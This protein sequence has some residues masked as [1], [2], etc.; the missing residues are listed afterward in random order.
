MGGRLDTLTRDT[1]RSYLH[2]QLAVLLQGGTLTLATVAIG[3][4]AGQEAL[5]RFGWVLSAV[6][7]VSLVGGLGFKEGVAVL[8]QREREDPEAL[9]GLFFRCL[10][11]RVAAALVAAIAVAAMVVANQGQTAFAAAVSAYVLFVLLGNLFAAFDIA[12]FRTRAVALGR[13]ASAVVGL[14]LTVAGALIGSLALVFAGLAAGAAAA[15]VIFLLPLAQLLKGARKSYALRGL[16]GLSLTLWL[17]AILNYLVGLNAAPLV[18]KTAHMGEG[19][20]G[21]FTAAF[22]LVFATN[23]ALTGGFANVI[24]AAFSRAGAS[25]GGESLAR[26][27]SLYVRVVAIL[28]V[29]LLLGLVVFARLAVRIPLKGDTA[30]AAELLVIL[31][32]A[33]VVIRLLGGGAHSAALYATGHHVGDLVIRFAFAAVSVAVTY[34]AAVSGNLKAAVVAAGAAGAGVIAAEWVYLHVKERIGMPVREL[35][36]IF[37]GCAAAALPAAAMVR[38]GTVFATILAI[39]IFVVGVVLAFG[40]VKPLQRGEVERIG[41]KGIVADILTRFESE[42]EDVG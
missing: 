13:L 38:I 25:E 31:A 16:F 39:V 3:K 15:A 42:D 18:L 5:G 8:A 10:V 20:I 17:I 40:V 35:G 27:H 23:R 29:P 24:L 19:Q 12:L 11:T 14:A 36:K 6:G 34:A 7:L 1:T 37:L 41:A 28:S 33:F 21:I 4:L 30:A 2:N 26:L 32:A 9:R 22:M